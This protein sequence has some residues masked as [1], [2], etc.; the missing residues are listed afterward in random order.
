MLIPI[1]SLMSGFCMWLMVTSGHV[2]QAEEH[3]FLGLTKEFSLH[4]S[5]HQLGTEGL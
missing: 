2:N 1:V 3:F 4:F 5:S